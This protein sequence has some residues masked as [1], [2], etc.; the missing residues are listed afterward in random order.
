MSLA[1]K[2]E[3]LHIQYRLFHCK[4]LATEMLTITVKVF[5]VAILY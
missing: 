3:A 5:T 2:K 4:L 1:G